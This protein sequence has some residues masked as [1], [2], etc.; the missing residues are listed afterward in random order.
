VAD[1]EPLARD[2]MASLARRDPDLELVGTTASGSETLAAVQEASPHLLLLDIQMPNLDGIAVAEQLRSK[3]FSPYI[4]FV[5][6]HDSFALQAFE[7]SVR[8]YLVKPVSKRRFSAAIRRAKKA[9]SAVMEDR[10]EPII[11]RDGETLVSVV[12]DDIIWIG[13]ANQYVRLRTID[14]SEYIISQSL[15]QFACQLPDKSFTRIHRSTLINNSRI[16]HVLSSNGSYLV[17]M[18][19]GTIHRVARNRKSLLPELL[20]WSRQNSQP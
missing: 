9:I 7:F 18:I 6:A 19:D 5:T 20:E 4:I 15:R 2:L 17:E 14:N 16:E 10:P 12:P 8:D 11:V 13:A 1:D 3:E